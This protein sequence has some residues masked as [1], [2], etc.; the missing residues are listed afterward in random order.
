MGAPLRAAWEPPPGIGTKSICLAMPALSRALPLM[1]R[2]LPSS[3]YFLKMPC[4]MAMY[5]GMWNPL[6]EVVRPTLMGVMS[7]ALAAVAARVAMPNANNTAGAVHL[8]LN[9]FISLLLVV[10]FTANR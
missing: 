8:F 7:A 5:E 2:Y 6:A 1:L 10:F 9:C 3:P 4:S